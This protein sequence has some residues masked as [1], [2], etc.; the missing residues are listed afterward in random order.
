[1]QE[2]KKLG[3]LSI[4]KI[5]GLFGLV[6]GLVQGIVFLISPDLAA[7]YGVVFEGW[8]A[9]VLMPIMGAVIYFISGVVVA[10]FYNL[11]AKLVGGVRIEF[12]NNAIAMKKK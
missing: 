11:F 6:L 8:K 2:I 1:M 10:V 9:I 4:A 3:I 7:M 12:G 5:A